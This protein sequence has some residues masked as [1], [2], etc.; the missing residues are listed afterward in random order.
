MKSRSLLLSC[1]LLSCSLSACS[2]LSRDEVVIEDGVVSSTGAL[3]GTTVP[4]DF[5]ILEDWVDAPVPQPDRLLFTSA[6]EV[7]DYFGKD[8]EDLSVSW[9]TE[10]AFYFSGGMQ[11]S[12]GHTV[13]IVSMTYD[14]AEA[15]LD[16]VARFVSP[17]LGCA[18]HALPELPY[19]LV[20]LPALSIPEGKQLTVVFDRQDSLH[21]CTVPENTEPPAPDCP[22]RR[23]GAM[24]TFENVREHTERFTAW[25][26][27]PA[28]ID[29]AKRLLATGEQRVPNFNVDDHTDCDITWSWHVDPLDA[30][31]ADVTIEWCDGIPSY[32]Q[33]NRIDWLAQDV[34][35]CPWGAKVVA[36][37][38]RR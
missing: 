20:K 17:G 16:V 14:A 5:E 30:E 34:R 37:D 25:V 15:R 23:G 31:W 2:L 4:V 18:T 3:D 22:V 9:G 13:K 6:T 24:I 26:A 19:A 8:Q 1:A 11:S 21:H 12:D 27:K 32:I 10:W 36:V 29:E 7:R 28:F 38:D 35:W 33:A